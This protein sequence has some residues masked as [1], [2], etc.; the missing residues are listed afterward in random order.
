MMRGSGYGRENMEYQLFG[1][2][3]MHGV[4][5]GEIFEATNNLEQG[6]YTVAGNVMLVEA[7][8]LI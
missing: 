8:T 2:C 3:Y 5:E 1:N 6:D 7:I 4:M